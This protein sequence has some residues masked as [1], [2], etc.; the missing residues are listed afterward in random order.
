MVATTPSCLIEPPTGPLQI[1]P[2]AADTTPLA[3]SLIIPT[4]NERRNIAAI[5]D[6]LT[7]LLEGTIPGSYELIV[8]D[9]NSPDL[10]WEAAL[11]LGNT[12]PQLRVMRRVEERGLSSA[13]IRGWQGARGEILGV[14][15]A[16]LQHPPEVLLKLLAAVQADADLAVASRHVEGGGVSEWSFIRRLLSRGAQTLGLLILPKVVGRVSDPMSGYFLVRRSAIASAPLYPKGYK[17]LLEVIGRGHLDT[18]AEVGY[19][20]QE[21]LEGESKVTWRQYIDYLHHLICLRFKG[22]ITPTDKPAPLGRFLRFG[23]VGFSGLF[24]DYAT[25]FLLFEQLG[26][27]LTTST[28]LSGE[29]A[30][31]NNFLWNDAWT[32]ADLAQQQKGW[33]ARLKRFLKFNL[34]CLAGLTLNTLIVNLLF[35]L[36]GFN[37]YLAKFIAIATVTLWNFWVNL[38]LSWRVTDTPEV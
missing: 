19:V 1:A 6:Q 38:K 11:A 37:P 10:T 34:I 20:F 25:F 9:D 32:F 22:R 24:V 12:Y 14:I 8:V 36:L 5:V 30:I 31:G 15:D 2:L 17:I 33:P 3:F 21:R 28:V 35:N 4:Y 26:L 18:I 16:D 29:L 23:L 27:G 13:V 7:R